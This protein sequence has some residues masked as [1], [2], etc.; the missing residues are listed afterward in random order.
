MALGKLAII[1]FLAVLCCSAAFSAEL[2]NPASGYVQ[3]PESKMAL[4]VGVQLRKP[5]LVTRRE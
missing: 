2:V 4:A 5:A 3:Q 1:V